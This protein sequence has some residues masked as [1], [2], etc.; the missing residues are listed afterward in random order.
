M[1]V[2]RVL[3]RITTGYILSEN[4]F[5]SLSV[6]QAGVN[7]ITNP[8]MYYDNGQIVGYEYLEAF[9]NPAGV[10]AFDFQDYI[11]GY[12]SIRLNNVR[13]GDSLKTNVTI[14]VKPETTYTFSFWAKADEPYTL[15]AYIAEQGGFVTRY[16][17]DVT[18]EWQRY[19][20]TFTTPSTVVTPVWVGLGNPVNDSNTI[21]FHTDGWQLEEG[22]LTTF[23]SG[24]LGDGYAW[25]GYSNNSASFRTAEATGGKIV[26]LKELGLEVTGY[27]GF[28]LPEPNIDLTGYATKI[29]S[30]LSGLTIE[31]RE[32]SIAGTICGRGICE[33][34]CSRS[35]IGNMIN[36][37]KGNCAPPL[38]LYYQPTDSCGDPCGDCMQI[39]VYYNGGMQGSIQSLYREDV[40]IDFIAPDP[41]FYAC[42]E[43]RQAIELE[44]PLTTEFIVG[45]GPDGEWYAM[46]GLES[47][48]ITSPTAITPFGEVSA[49]HLARD[50]NLYIAGFIKTTDGTKYGLIGWN[51]SSF[52]QAGNTN[53]EIRDMVSCTDGYMYVATSMN[54]TIDGPTNTIVSGGLARYN[55][56]TRAWQNIGGSNGSNTMGGQGIFS[57]DCGYNGTGIVFGGDFLQ[58][59]FSPS[60]AYTSIKNVGV[61]YPGVGASQLGSNGLGT[62]G[63]GIALASTSNPI[64]VI[65]VNPYDGT[66]WAGGN[67][68]ESL[69]PTGTPSNIS[70]LVNGEW[71]YIDP[72]VVY[73][74]GASYYNMANA[75]VVDDIEFDEG[76]VYI[77]G[78]F[79]HSIR[80]LVYSPP[81]LGVLNNIAY[82][83]PPYTANW[84]DLDNGVY[85]TV[86]AEPQWVS[87]VTDIDLA[88]GQL[89]VTGVFNKA[90]DD[91]PVNVCGSAIWDGSKWYESGFKPETV[92][93]REFVGGPLYEICHTMFVEIGN[94]YQYGNT[95]IANSEIPLSTPAGSIFY[96]GMFRDYNRNLDGIATVPYVA[97][98]DTGCSDSV[99]PVI[100]ICGITTVRAIINH[101]NGTRLDFAPLDD[102]AP[103]QLGDGECITLDLTGDKKSVTDQ[104]GNNRQSLLAAGTV[105]GSFTLNQ[106]INRIQV[107][108]E[109]GDPTGGVKFIWRNRYMNGDS[110]DK[111]CC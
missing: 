88:N 71:T 9:L 53:G 80:W 86:E 58:G 42:N 36:P 59:Y 78:H 3:P 35:K 39:E 75:A 67:F 73:T 83:D 70:R 44:V 102:G 92:T 104:D 16:V 64:E 32:L 63:G 69:S 47:T 76:R 111:D 74:A 34:L 40:V 4:G 28:G 15:S 62:A 89:Y 10:I 52:F 98:I 101:T 21:S 61:W 12:N 6:P 54:A 99:S 5:F 11:V 85:S 72:V 7:L 41:Y 31:A 49:M 37:Y 25:T 95:G 8:E 82:L 93:T 94:G 38:T 96:S 27:T 105:L 68:R 57:V 56:T 107:L 48:L 66:V 33:L 109:N 22:S 84:Q 14:G 43:T 90:G 55:L 106:G 20:H 77:G 18:Q 13:F 23:I 45:Q 19:S 24:N 50:G 65:R 51:G 91:N 108:G 110:V 100:E 60:F 30:A 81:A 26:S 29:G 17:F 2:H 103:Y 79:T 97:T 46:E 1:Q 87:R